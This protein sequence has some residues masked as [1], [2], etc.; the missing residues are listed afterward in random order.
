MKELYTSEGKKIEFT[1]E[2]CRIFEIE[3]G[4]IEKLSTVTHNGMTVTTFRD[5]VRTVKMFWGPWI[6][7]GVESKHQIQ[8]T[9]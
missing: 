2:G 6:P 8:L 5:V 9:D 1:P 7:F 4:D 3:V